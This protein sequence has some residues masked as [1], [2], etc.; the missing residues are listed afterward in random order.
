MVSMYLAGSW[1]GLTT[2]IAC[3][4]RRATGMQTARGGSGAR[5]CATSRDGVTCSGTCGGT[6]SGSWRG[7]R[8]HALRSKLTA[9][10]C[11]FVISSA[12]ERV[13]HLLTN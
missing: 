13:V 8:S 10:H 2:R 5:A 1:V 3:S 6:Y 12:I 7:T 11:L 9:L 4:T